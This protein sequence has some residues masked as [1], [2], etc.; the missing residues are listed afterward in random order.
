MPPLLIKGFTWVAGFGA[1]K[2]ALAVGVAVIG[3]IL[4]WLWNDY[5]DRGVR[6]VLLRA[7]AERAA[8]MHE[9]AL[10]ARDTVE[11]QLRSDLEALRAVSDRRAEEADTLRLSID[12]LKQVERPDDQAS[13]PVHP[14][15]ELALDELR[16]GS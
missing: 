14:A 13:C 7:D 12:K 10:R 8:Q 16:L 5:Q 9:D 1:K 2:I 4:T 3:G 11:A 15:I 6:I